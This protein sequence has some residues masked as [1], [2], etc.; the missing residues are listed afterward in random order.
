MTSKKEYNILI[1]SIL[2]NLI[3]F[4][5]VRLHPGFEGNNVCIDSMIKPINVNLFS[6]NK[7]KSVEK[8]VGSLSLKLFSNNFLKLFCFLFLITYN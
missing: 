7:L 5:A 2:N 6:Y 1:F 3:N 4:F 8:S